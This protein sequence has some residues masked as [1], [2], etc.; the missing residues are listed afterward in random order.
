MKTGKIER[1]TR[2]AV[3]HLTFIGLGLI[4]LLPVLW[5]V[6]TSFKEGS[7]AFSYPFR[8]LPTTWRLSNYRS[9]WEEL[10][11]AR[12][13][14]NSLIIAATVTVG[15]LFSGTLAG[16]A[17]ARLRFPGR[18]LLFYLYLSSMMVPHHVTLIPS[19]LILKWLGLIDT[20][21]AL[22][23]PFLAG[24]F[25]A[26]LMRQAFLEIPRSFEDA[27]RIDGATRFQVL[28]R[29]MLPLVRPTLLTLAIFIFIWQW[30]SFLWPLIV[31]QRAS[32]RT[33]PVGIASLRTEFGSDWPVLMAANVMIVLPMLALFFLAQRQFIRGITLNEAAE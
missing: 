1:H 20:Y 28:V 19:F 23:L 4:M 12:L 31:T 5:M 2:T 9:V 22:I 15:Q 14:L 13:Y 30:N 33:L 27:A 24:A 7:E 8:W 6:F 18:N 16:Y 29:I 25:G 17:F 10:P 26:F 3:Y 32:M 11:F 21:P